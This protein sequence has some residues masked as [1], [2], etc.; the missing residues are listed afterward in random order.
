MV[1]LGPLVVSRCMTAPK[2]L[3]G[4]G[5]G[6]LLSSLPMDRFTQLQGKGSAIQKIYSG[7]SGAFHTE[8]GLNVLKGHKW[9]VINGNRAWRRRWR[10]AWGVCVGHWSQSGFSQLHHSQ[11]FRLGSFQD[12]DKDRKIDFINKR[13]E[14]RQERAKHSCTSIHAAP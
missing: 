3:F 2:L 7:S 14:L 6:G 8:L 11:I 5:V 1:L 9:V 13:I 12:P 4:S 10:L